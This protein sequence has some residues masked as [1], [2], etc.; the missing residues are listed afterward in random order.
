[1]IGSH[2]I[3]RFYLEQFATRS[4]RGKKQAGFIWVYEVGKK[5]RRR[6]TSVQGVEN[7]YFGF[8]RPDGSLQEEFEEE[9]ARRENECNE[10]LVCAKSPLFS[11]PRGSKEK[12][13]FYA[14]LLYSRATQ[15]RSF[16]EANYSKII[17]QLEAA[18]NDSKLIKDLAN[19]LTVK[20]G[21]HCPESAVLKG[22]DSWLENARNV[23]SANNA[24]LGTLL[25]NTSLIADA[26]L[27]KIPW[28]VLRPPDGL[29]FVTSD[30]P[31]ITFVPLGNG[32]L[33]PGYGFRKKQAITCADEAGVAK[34][35]R[36]DNQSV[37]HIFAVP[38][39][40]SL[41]RCLP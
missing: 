22:I 4:G 13:A 25:E 27:Q 40:N 35:K 32:K 28:R 14:A 20:T 24:F 1:M 23:A 10:V 29:E 39:D 21:M 15:R 17:I 33:H 34:K 2:I 5:P 36:L 8:M 26:L 31:L 3:P 11:W 38:S 37:R 19:A 7:G 9:L 41:G 18:K 12:L 16:S 6:G 30:N